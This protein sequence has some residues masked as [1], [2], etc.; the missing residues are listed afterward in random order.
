M[1]ETPGAAPVRVHFGRRRPADRRPAVVLLVAG[2]LVLLATPFGAGALG[3]M[4]A[5]IAIVVGFWMLGQGEAPFR[6]EA[7]AELLVTTAA[8]VIRRAD[9]LPLVTAD[10]V[11]GG[12]IEPAG[13]T[14]VAVLALRDG[15][16]AALWTSDEPTARALLAAVGADARAA[17]MRLAR[18]TP[19]DRRGA[20]CL[21]AALFV[22]ALLFVLG[23][24]AF[25]FVAVSVAIAEG[26]FDDLRSV[27][28]VGAGALPFG[29]LV[30][31]LADRLGETRLR[32]GHD[33]VLVDAGRLRRR[34]IAHAEMEDVF[35]EDATLHV[36]TAA[37]DVRVRCGS[38]EQ[39]SAA[40]RRVLDARARRER[41]AHARAGAIVARRG[42]GLDRWRDR[43]AGVLDAAQGHYRGAAVDEDQLL[44]LVDDADAA[45][46]LRVGAAVALARSP[47]ATRERVRVAAQA[48]AEPRL[49]AL[50]ERAAEGEV[51]DLAL[52]ELEA[53]HAER[54][55][56]RGRR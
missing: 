46:E 18:G 21:L 13:T 43:L 34:F 29:L 53:A 31:A 27:L 38:A 55:L 44:A 39:A 51:D 4:T 30:A 14:S 33:G 45:P 36:R 9:G 35:A 48:Q 41:A 50:L 24:L 42:E 52:A 11:A 16:H 10:R 26:S 49:A 22:P 3:V 5:L 54:R 25:L 23:Y 7:R 15:S 12:W 28:L 1:E 32:I 20:S 47:Q 17:T 37:R 40:A 2:A 8:G 19:V 56:H 6:D